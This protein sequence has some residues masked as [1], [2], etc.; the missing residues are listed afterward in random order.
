MT[1]RGI[2]GAGDRRSTA[3]PPVEQ[4]CRVGLRALISTFNARS[5]PAK[6]YQSSAR[7]LSPIFRPSARPLGLEISLRSVSHRGF[8]L[9]VDE[10]LGSLLDVGAVLVVEQPRIA[11]IV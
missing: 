5:R 2:S 8:E 3:G 1:D 10:T 9:L 4:H 7:T 11:Q 6:T